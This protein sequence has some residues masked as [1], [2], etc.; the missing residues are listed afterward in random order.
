MKAV[1]FI[2]KHLALFVAKKLLVV[3][4]L[5]QLFQINVDNP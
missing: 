3:D 4:V 1:M 5:A 2:G